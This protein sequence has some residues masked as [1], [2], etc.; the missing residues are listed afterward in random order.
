MCE[1]KALVSALY[2][3]RQVCELILAMN[4]GQQDR[5]IHATVVGPA[6]SSPLTSLASLHQQA[7]KLK[8]TSVTSAVDAGN[9][10]PSCRR[11]RLESDSRSHSHLVPRG[12]LEHYPSPRGE[13]D[14]ALQPTVV[15]PIPSS[16]NDFISYE[17]SSSAC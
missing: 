6:P 11:G 10:D 14:S 1:N 3:H 15:A 17:N 13:R 5:N 9:A 2:Q 16:H 4:P 12:S 7:S 8:E